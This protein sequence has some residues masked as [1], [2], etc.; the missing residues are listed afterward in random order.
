[1]GPEPSTSLRALHRTTR[2]GTWLCQPSL[3]PVKSK[4]T[5]TPQ[6]PFYWTP[7]RSV[8]IPLIYICIEPKIMKC[9]NPAIRKIVQEPDFW[10]EIDETDVSGVPLCLNDK[11]IRWGSNAASISFFLFRKPLAPPIRFAWLNCY[12]AVDGLL[13]FVTCLQI[14]W[15]Y[16]W[17]P[18]VVETQMLR[19]GQFLI[20]AVPGEFTTMAGRRLRQQL[21]TEA[22]NFGAP[23][24]TKVV[25]A[26]LSNVYT[27]YIT[28]FEEYQVSLP[29]DF[30]LW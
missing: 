15:P 27:H 17:H 30:R 2:F 5:A 21:V 24:N 14:T 12:G 26:G 13:Y 16:K 11:R 29:C 6:N 9:L 8:N 4:L 7:V 28:T 18:D 25:I 20:A 22:V 23:I 1:M 3:H 19:I 10:S